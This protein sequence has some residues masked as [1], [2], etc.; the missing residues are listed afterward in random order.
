MTFRGATRVRILLADDDE[1]SRHILK[2]T[3]SRWGFDVV[4]AADGDQ[5]WEV[6]LAENAPRLV[7]LDW[8]MPGMDGVEVCRRV[9]EQLSGPY[10]YMLLLTSKREKEDMIRGMEA[11]ADDY[12]SKPFDPQELQMRLKA[13]E[14]IIDLQEKLLQAQQ[15]LQYMATH[16]NLSGLQNRFSILES[17]RRELSRASREGREVGI[18]LADIDHFKRVNDSLGHLAGD[19]VLQEVAGR[20]RNHVRPYDYV[21]RY[22][23]EEFLI[24]LPE[25]PLR[26]TRNAAE[27]MQRAVS[28]EPVTLAEG[29]VDVTISLGV[30]GYGRGATDDLQTIIR[31]ADGALYRAKAA[32]RN[33]VVV[34]DS[35]EFN[36]EPPPPALSMEKPRLASA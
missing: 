5:A 1:V 8:M 6:L 4:T 26:A 35:A 12:V 19:A 2:G 27:R 14:R 34:A 28:Q 24:V 3:L 10:I 29:P 31:A 36:D 13:G 33:R 20:L 17:L 15:E 18:I 11:G 25:C 22:G 30:T 9:R 32:G 7:I 21:G 23:G 16:D